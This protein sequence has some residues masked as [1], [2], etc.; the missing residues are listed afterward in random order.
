M[1]MTINCLLV[2]YATVEIATWPLSVIIVFSFTSCLLGMRALAISL[3]DPF[4]GDEVCSRHLFARA[5]HLGGA[6]AVSLPTTGTAMISRTRA[7]R[8]FACG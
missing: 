3:S 4:G 7:R 5:S 8:L 1:I 6:L 2:A